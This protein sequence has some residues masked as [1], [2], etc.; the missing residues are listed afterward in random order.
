[1]KYFLGLAAAALVALPCYA[2]GFEFGGSPAGS[3]E[4][5][6]N[7]S[8]VI[9]TSCAACTGWYNNSG[10][11]DDTNPNYIV[12]TISTTGFNDYFV[13]DIPVGLVITSAQLSIGNP[14]NGYDSASTSLL[15][16]LFDVSTPVETLESPQSGATAI[17]NDLGSGVLY[18]STSVDAST[19]GNQVTVNLDAAAIA[20]LTAAEGDAF[21]FGGTLSP[22]TSTVPE[23][24]A[25]FLLGTLIAVVGWKFRK[26]GAKA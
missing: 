25:V 9:D 6:L 20:S 15:W 23:P 13:F 8:T 19:D 5:I 16:S 12:G 3:Q 17:Y 10:V 14:G 4:L 7:G 22:S 24:S 26:R 18:G 2:D 11:H 1:M 21:A